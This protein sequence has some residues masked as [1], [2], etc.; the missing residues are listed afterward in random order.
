MGNMTFDDS[1]QDVARRLRQ[2]E[3]HG[4]PC[5]PVRDLLGADDIER[6]YQVQA[7]N[8]AL[9]VGSGRR[10]VGWKVGLTSPA[11]QRQLG[12]DQPDSGALYEDFEVGDGLP[13]PFDRLLQP[14]VEAEVAFVLDRDLD[15]PITAA[16]VLRATAFVLPAIEI[17]DSRIVDWDIGIVDTVAD[18]ASSA[19]YV[20][21]PSPRRITDV[22]LHAV[23]MTMTSSGEVVSKGSGEAC[24]GHPVNAVVWLANTRAALGT[25][26]REGDLVLSGALGPMVTAKRG[27]IYEAVIDGLGSVRANFLEEA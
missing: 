26:L 8:H 12:V 21:G 13:V 6:A 27:S 25:P 24:L 10:V 19:M 11:V 23:S 20:L 16:G 22:D 7:Y 9:A 2:A 4:A 15:G 18:N 3:E 17:V 1:V 5:P 14:K